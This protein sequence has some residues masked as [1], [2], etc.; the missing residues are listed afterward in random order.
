MRL[1]ADCGLDHEHFIAKFRLKLKKVGKT[2]R[3]FRF[4]LNQ[5]PYDY[6]VE[7]TNR[8]NGIDLIERLPEEVWIEV[9]DIIQEAEIKT[10]PKK[11]K[12][13]KAKW[14]SEKGLQTAIKIR[15]V[16]GIGEKE[17]YAFECRVP[18][19]SKER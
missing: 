1:G 10:I 5:T 14:F 16:K 4:D 15:E 18:K 13:K 6:T 11:R 12:C 7:V 2:T 8:F 9:H 19:K 17:T 3:T